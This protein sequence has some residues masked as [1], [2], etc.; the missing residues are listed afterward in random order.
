MKLDVVFFLQLELSATAASLLQTESLAQSYAASLKRGVYWFARYQHWDGV[1][2][3]H[4]YHEGT[5]YIWEHYWDHGHFGVY[6]QSTSFYN[7]MEWR[8]WHRLGVRIIIS[9]VLPFA[10]SLP[11]SSHYPYPILLFCF[12]GRACESASA[13]TALLAWGSKRS[14]QLH[15]NGNFPLSARRFHRTCMTKDR[16]SLRRS[17][18]G[19]QSLAI[20]SMCMESKWRRHAASV[21]LW[22]SFRGKR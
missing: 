17:H 6:E 22:F 15:Y 7:F 11:N 4:I 13:A 19:R 20:S 12:Y 10:S 5:L 14:T 21:C 9:T 3:G 1:I 2:S 18:V 8:S 16:V